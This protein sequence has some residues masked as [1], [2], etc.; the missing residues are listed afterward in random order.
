M[1]NMYERRAARRGAKQEGRKEV[2]QAKQESGAD[3]GKATEG[4]RPKMKG[5]GKPG[6]MAR[7]LKAA[8]GSAKKGKAK[9]KAMSY[10]GKSN[11]YK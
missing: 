11:A 4:D 2:R 3:K 8:H 9:R 1:P 7:F 10:K 6:R 5:G